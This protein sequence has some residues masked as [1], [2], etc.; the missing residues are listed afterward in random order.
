MAKPRSCLLASF[1]SARVTTGDNAR[2]SRVA[3]LACLMLL[4]CAAAVIASPAQSF[5]TLL[6][7]DRTDGA[8]PGSMSLVQGSD[9]NFYGTTSGGG[10]YNRG[11]IFKITPEGKLTTLHSSCSAPNCS[12][13]EYPNGLIQGKDGNFYGTAILGG[14]YALGTVFRITPDGTLTTLHSFDGTDGLNPESTLIQGID[15]SFY[16][17]T[18]AYYRNG[19]GT[20]FK[21]SPEGDF[22][23]LYT[24][25]SLPGCRDGKFPVGGLTQAPNGNFYG[26]TD[27]G[28]AYGYGTVFSMTAEGTL[29]TLHSFDGTDGSN[30]NVTL[31]QGRDGNFYGTTNMSGNQNNGTVFKITPEGKLTTL[32]TFCSLAGCRDGLFPS[33]GLVQ[34]TDGN[35]Y[36]IT[37]EGGTCYGCG[38]VF[39]ITADGMLTTLHNFGVRGGE[40]PL[41]GLLQASNGNF[42]GT[43]SVG[44]PDEAGTIFGL[45]VGIGSFVQTP[46]EFGKVGTKFIVPGN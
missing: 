4:F 38:T 22:I 43:T 44:G 29:T 27:L 2:E 40:Q 39:R 34:A 28:G 45:S 8:I 32:H 37:F 16:G 46:D 19:Q 33:G 1:S 21:I 35:F 14:D 7:F 13:G 42:Y 10:A 30:P 36:G 41:G 5:E 31:V 3:K 11:T 12:D 20:V 17:T 15:G 25:C 9:G 23:T 24:F 6:V 18:S 26:T